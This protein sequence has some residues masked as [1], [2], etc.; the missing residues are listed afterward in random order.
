MLN[1]KFLKGLAL[2]GIGPTS[3]TV[4]L[5]QS[6]GIPCV[7]DISNFPGASWEGKEAIVDGELGLLAVDLTASARRY[8]EMEQ[9]R[10]NA[11]KAP[12]RSNES[13]RFQARPPT[14]LD[15]KSQ[16]IF[17]VPTKLPPLFAA[18]AESIGLFRTEMLFMDR[19]DAPGEE[20]QCEA[21]SRALRGAQGRMVIIRTLDIREATSLWRG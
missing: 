8:Y 12:Q 18:G 15:W 16:Q 17:P 11:R 2:S 14:G 10:L 20:E 9:W 19:A 1:R 6:F 21:Y 13:P 7:I 5:A 4:I 3:H